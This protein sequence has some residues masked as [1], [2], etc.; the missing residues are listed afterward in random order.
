MALIYLFFLYNYSCC[1]T[2]SHLCFY[3]RKRLQSLYRRHQ[4]QTSRSEKI[5]WRLVKF[6]D[7]IKLILYDFDAISFCWVYREANHAAHSL[8]KWSLD[9]SFFGSF[10]KGFSPTSLLILQLSGPLIV[11]FLALLIVLL[12]SPW[13]YSNSLVQAAQAELLLFLFVNKSFLSRKKK[14]IYIY[15]YKCYEIIGS[16]SIN[17]KSL[18]YPNTT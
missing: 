17:R 4:C 14:K 12:I 15:I 13:C 2:S 18:I 5:T 11:L 3:Y 6:V 1:P 16:H 10:D 8:T 9:S 7:T